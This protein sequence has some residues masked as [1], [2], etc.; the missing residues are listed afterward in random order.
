MARPTW[1]STRASTSLTPSPVTE[2]NLIIPWA[3][4]NFLTWSD[5]PS[6]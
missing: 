6:N 5:S 3:K 4:V 1:A 2:T